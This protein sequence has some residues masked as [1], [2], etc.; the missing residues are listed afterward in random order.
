MLSVHQLDILEIMLD[1]CLV[2]FY[3]SFYVQLVSS[4]SYPLLQHYLIKVI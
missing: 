2:C 1:F 3:A 4:V